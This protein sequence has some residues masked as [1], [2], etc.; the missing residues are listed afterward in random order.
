MPKYYIESGELKKEVQ[1]ED[2]LTTVLATLENILK[3]SPDIML[4][5]SL[6][7]N[8]RGFVCNLIGSGVK[9]LSRGYI[10]VRKKNI[11]IVETLHP[12]IEMMT[13]QTIFL[14]VEQ[15][16]ELIPRE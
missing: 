7:V 4:G 16:I 15:L 13:G 3:I 2:F 1:G 9:G 8:E 14:P 10:L 12:N 11:R 5:E 6:S